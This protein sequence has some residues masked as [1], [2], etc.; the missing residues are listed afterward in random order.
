MAIS[1]IPVD[2]M[3]ASLLY[4][5]FGPSTSEYA[6]ERILLFTTTT[7]AP[8]VPEH[9]LQPTCFKFFE[10]NDLDLVGYWSCNFSQSGYTA[11][12]FKYKFLQIQLGS[13]TW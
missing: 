9:V 13:T 5:Y 8:H 11:T 6:I 10:V 3:D 1:P 2:F 7:T 12:D 4:G